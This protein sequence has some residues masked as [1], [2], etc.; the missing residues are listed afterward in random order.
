MSITKEE[1]APLS[2]ETALRILGYAW[3][4]AP[5]DQI[6]DGD[7]KATAIAILKAAAAEL[8]AAGERRTRSLSRNGTSMSFDAVTGPFSTDDWATLRRLA[9]VSGASGLPVGSFPV[10]GEIGRVWP[11]RYVP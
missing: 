6:V 5:L 4:V 10:G 9:G 1:L 7:D 3:N 2:T 11:E 8:P